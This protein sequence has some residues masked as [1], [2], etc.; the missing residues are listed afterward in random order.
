MRRWQGTADSPLNE[1][2]RQQA[3]SDRRADSRRSTTASTRC[4]RATRPGGGDRRD[5]RR[6]ARPRRA[7][8]DRPRLREAFA[9]EWQ[10]LTRTRSSGVAGL[11]R[12]TTVRPPTFE[13]FEAVVDRATARSPTSPRRRRG[14]DGRDVVVAHS[15]V[16]RSLIRELGDHR[17]ARSEPRRGV[18]QRGRLV[19]RSTSLFS[20]GRPPP[21][22]TLELG[23]CSI[24]GRS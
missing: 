20:H 12:R 8:V 4:G 22:W 2:G 15:G 11:A 10:G 7:E 18:A 17:R 21:A 1:V 5:H 14:R 3:T 6:D 24:P 9:G 23:R 19:D 13:P 16:I